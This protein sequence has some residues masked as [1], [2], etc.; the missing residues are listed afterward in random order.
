MSESIEN[1]VR[2]FNDRGL[3]WLLESPNNFEHFVRL[4]ASEIADR[5]DFTRAERIPRSFI[6]AELEKTE[7]DILYR[8]PARTGDYEVLIYIL[9]ELQSAPDNEIGFNIY[10][11]RGE[12]WKHEKR[13]WQQSST[14]RSDFKLHLIV[15]I[16]FYTGEK[17]WN[18]PDGMEGL[19]ETPE[20]MSEF[21]PNWKTLF[22]SLSAT[23]VEVLIG[24]GTGLALALRG[25]QAVG[26]DLEEMKAVVAQIVAGLSQLPVESQVEWKTVIH[27]LLL[28]ILHKRARSEHNTLIGVIETAVDNSHREEVQ[29]M[30]FSE[31]DYLQQ[32][33]REEGR[34]ESL[35]DLLILLTQ[36]KFGP[37][38]ENIIA[39]MRSLHEKDGIE[40][41]RRLIR[42]KTIDE[43]GL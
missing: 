43:L 14:P 2:E 1:V 3:I 20:G 16:V 33:G 28:L 27:F 26:S 10:L 12:I 25:L 15:P 36:D 6:S 22:V 41:G 11:R 23:P 4:F 9:N 40:M 5:L 19:I 42:A 18:I 17:T 37:L 30:I 8:L 35:R 38:S 29:I 32:K 13:I 7:T 24:A 34:E 31:A 39:K 21:N